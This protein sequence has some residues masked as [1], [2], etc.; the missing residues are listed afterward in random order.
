MENKFTLQDFLT[1]HELLVTLS[2]ETK[3]VNEHVDS[4]CIDQYWFHLNELLEKLGNTFKEQLITKDSIEKWTGKKIHSFEK[5][6]DEKGMLTGV[7]VVPVKTVE[8]ITITF[9]V[10]P[11]GVSV[12]ENK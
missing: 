1:M 2:R 3:P 7:N 9:N 5:V 6:Y 4:I 11:T 8:Y 10:T 12:E